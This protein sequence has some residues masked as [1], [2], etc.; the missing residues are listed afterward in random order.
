M[1]AEMRNAIEDGRQSGDIKALDAPCLQQL[2]SGQV[3]EHLLGLAHHG[4]KLPQQLVLGDAATFGKLR[5]SLANIDRTAHAGNDPLTH[6]A[7]QM[8]KQVADAIERRLGARPDLLVVQLVQ[9]VFDSAL[10]AG[11]FVAGLR[12]DGGC[13]FIGSHAGSST[14]SKARPNRRSRCYNDNMDGKEKKFYR[15]LKR[16]IKQKGNRK[17]RQAAKRDLADNPTEAHWFQEGFG[18]YRSDWLN[19]LDRSPNS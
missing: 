10:G 15:E 14:I 16:S 3:A 4:I 17:R 5:V 2:A 19:G 13:Q 6:I 11:Q 9:T 12:S 1:P 7:A 8:E 18:K